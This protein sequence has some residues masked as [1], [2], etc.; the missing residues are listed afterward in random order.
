MRTWNSRIE[1]VR[2]LFKDGNWNTVALRE[3]STAVEECEFVRFVG[4][5]RRR[6]ALAE[7]EPL[8]DAAWWNAVESSCH[9]PREQQT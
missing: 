1:G 3:N 9:F 4:P 2:E 8:E 5:S 7:F 6:D